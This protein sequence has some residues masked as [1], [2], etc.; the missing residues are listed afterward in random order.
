MIGKLFGAWLGEK[1]AGERSGAKGAMLGYG[2]AA[3]ARRSV[4]ALAALALGGWAWRRWRDKRRAEPV[5]SFGRFAFLSLA[6]GGILEVGH[7]L[8]LQL[9][10]H[11]LAEAIEAA[12][13][14]DTDPAFGDRVFDD[15]GLFLPIELDADAAAEQRLVIKF[16]PRVEREAVGR[17]VCAACR[18]WPRPSFAG[19][20]RSM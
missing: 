16:A 4:P 17:A 15:A 9:D 11:R 10:G 8:A 19:L 6:L 14:G 18:P 5:L 12:A 3:L 13:R 2:A 1:V 20:R 7:D